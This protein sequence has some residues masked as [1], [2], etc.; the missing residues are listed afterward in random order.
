LLIKWITINLNKKKKKTMNSEKVKKIRRTLFPG[1]AKKGRADLAERLDV[2]P[3]T[4]KKWELGGRIPAW[5]VRNLE[6]LEK[7]INT[8]Y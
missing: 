3:I 6:A 1:T 2:K 5:Q 7:K 4:V 8:N